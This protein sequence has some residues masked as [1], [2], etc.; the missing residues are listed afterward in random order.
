MLGK[1]K[2]EAVAVAR[3]T[4]LRQ[5][6][7]YEVEEEYPPDEIFRKYFEA[8][9]EPLPDSGLKALQVPDGV[10][11]ETSD[12]EADSDWSGFSDE[13]SETRVEIIEHSSSKRSTDDHGD[14]VELRSFMV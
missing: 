2:R 10:D 13:A 4:Q 1:R 5:P 3:D 9:F 11:S 6:T 14:K 12:E 7:A 8:K